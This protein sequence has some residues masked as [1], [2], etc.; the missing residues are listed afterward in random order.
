[1]NTVQTKTNLVQVNVSCVRR[2]YFDR[3]QNTLCFQAIG[4]KE[5][6][7]LCSVKDQT[8]ARLVS[9]RMV[10]K[11]NAPEQPEANALADKMGL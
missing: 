2:F 8:E 3:A 6:H 4:E 10:D 11:D 9:Y 7:S 5:M 1:M